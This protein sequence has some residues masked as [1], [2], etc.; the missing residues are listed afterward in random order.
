ML[1]YINLNYNHIELIK[2]V[3]VDSNIGK[4]ICVNYITSSIGKVD[5]I[6]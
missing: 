3:P 6:G 5:I 2:Q 1:R 4:K